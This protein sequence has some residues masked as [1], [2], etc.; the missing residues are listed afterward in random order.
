[1]YTGL[2]AKSCQIIIKLIFSPQILK[3]SSNT[4][5]HKNPPPPNSEPSH[6]MQTDGHNEAKIRFSQFREGA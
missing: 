5:F 1:M 4:K 3:E 2:N 6:S